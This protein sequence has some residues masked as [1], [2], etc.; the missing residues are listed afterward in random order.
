MMVR[1]SE[2]R[3]VMSILSHEIDQENVDPAV[4]NSIYTATKS[5]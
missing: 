4:V 2:S 5:K 1:K 3:V